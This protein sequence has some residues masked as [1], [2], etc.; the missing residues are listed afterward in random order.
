M[1]LR[2]TSPP[3]IHSCSL[4]SPN[5]TDGRPFAEYLLDGAKSTLDHW[6]TINRAAFVLLSILES[7]HESTV[8]RLADLLRPLVPALSKSTLQGP[9]GLLKVRYCIVRS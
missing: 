3:L 5:H 6:A 2:T 7:K 8:K 9:S 1:H 4:H